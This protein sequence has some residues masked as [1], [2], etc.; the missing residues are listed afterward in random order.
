MFL[1]CWLRW[2][3]HGSADTI[4]STFRPGE[5]IKYRMDQ[6]GLKP[7]DLIP[8]IG[9]RNRAHEVLNRRRSLTLKM[10]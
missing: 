3:R 6:N 7:R 4:R 2:S 9:S 5:A 1:M 8:F 10:I